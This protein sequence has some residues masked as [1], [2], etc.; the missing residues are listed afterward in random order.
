[1]G[2]IMDKAKHLF[3]LEKTLLLLYNNKLYPNVKTKWPSV[4]KEELSLVEFDGFKINKKF[5][6]KVLNGLRGAPVQISF[7]GCRTRIK[8]T[9]RTW[10]FFHLIILSY[11]GVQLIHLDN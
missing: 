1:M 4:I 11:T 5:F 6:M 7:K 8:K 9:A 3:L 2:L 10:L